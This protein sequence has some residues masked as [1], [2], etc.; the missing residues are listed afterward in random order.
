VSKVRAVLDANVL[1]GDFV[2]DLFLSLFAAEL[3]EAKWTDKITGEWVKH[4]L[5]NNPEAS[6]KAK[7]DRTVAFMNQVSPSAL[8][9][10]YEQ[11]IA[12]VDI[13]DVDDRHV[14]VAAIACGAQKI[15]T[16]NL[17][18][19]SNRCSHHSIHR[20]FTRQVPLRLDH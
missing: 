5:A 14:V 3:Y 10:R 18:D 15:V 17:R 9:E 13:P 8:V 19:S 12:R 11:Y 7:T 16:F 6:T 2:R 4:L 1:Y 20:G